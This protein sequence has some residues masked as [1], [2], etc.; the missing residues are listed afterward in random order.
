MPVDEVLASNRT[1]LGKINLI[2][3]GRTGVGMSTLVNAV[4][5]ACEETW[6]VLKTE[7]ENGRCDPNAT[8]HVHMGAACVQEPRLRMEAAEQRLVDPLKCTR[9][10]AI[11]VLTKTGVFPE[12]H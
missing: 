1:K 10:P 8:K 3:A 6:A 11:V 5:G 7:V 12:F 4:F 2:V 9:I